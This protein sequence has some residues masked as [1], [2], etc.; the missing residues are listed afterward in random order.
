MK[1]KLTGVESKMLMEYMLNGYT[2]KTYHLDQLP[3][4]IKT[5][6]VSEQLAAQESLNSFKGTQLLWNQQL[7]L[8]LLSYGLVSVGETKFESVDAAHQYLLSKPD[9]L[10]NK[11]TDAQARLQS[12][13]KELL[14]R[15]DDFSGSPS[16]SQDSTSSSEDVSSSK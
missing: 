15:S 5:L 11:F 6:T 13:I 14:D 12:E 16:L 4:V 10:V 8:M 1:E 2:E 9:Q 7:R 3:F